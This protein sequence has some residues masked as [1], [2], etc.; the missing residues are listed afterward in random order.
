VARRSPDSYEEAL[1]DVIRK[2]EAPPGVTV[3]HRLEEGDTV[4]DILTAAQECGAD[5]IVMGTH[6]RT[7]L[8]R[9]LMGSVAENVVRRAPCAV[10]TVR[11]HGPVGGVPPEQTA[12]TANA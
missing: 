9:V 1:W 8:R 4:E 2:Y 3:G 7:G 11:D 10:L 12:V 5:L 6:G